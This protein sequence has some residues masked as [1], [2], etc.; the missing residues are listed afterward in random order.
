V[1]ALILHFADNFSG[2]FLAVLS[3]REKAMSEIH[4]KTKNRRKDGN[5]APAI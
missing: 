2:S 4:P 3:Q 5:P 1:D